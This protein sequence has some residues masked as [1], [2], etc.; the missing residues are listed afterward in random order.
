MSEE[1]SGIQR[2]QRTPLVS[3]AI[4]AG[5][6]LICA[7]YWPVAPLLP[8]IC[9]LFLGLVFLFIKKDAGQAFSVVALSIVTFYFYGIV[10]FHVVSKKHFSRTMGHQSG[11]T[12]LLKL[13]VIDDPRLRGVVTAARRTECL[14]EI[15]EIK[16]K[17]GWQAVEGK[18][19]VRTYDVRN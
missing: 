9:F 17:N 18:V 3:V 13:R 16:S 10:S 14:A 7:M 19:L 12:M 1:N 2:S 5:I 15:I 4:A 8:F 11:E 6:G